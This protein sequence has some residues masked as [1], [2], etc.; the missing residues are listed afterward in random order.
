MFIGAI[1]F[2]IAKTGNPN[3]LHLGSEKKIWVQWNTT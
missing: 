1:L 2:E 3:G